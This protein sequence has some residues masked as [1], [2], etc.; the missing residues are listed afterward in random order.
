[1][2][3]KLKKEFK[4]IDNVVLFGLSAG[5]NLVLG[6][7]YWAILNNLPLPKGVVV[8][9]PA[10]NCDNTKFTRSNIWSFNCE[11]LPHAYLRMFSK[12]YL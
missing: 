7:C 5:G 6:V 12:A 10:L 2:T 3:N 1:M 4:K 9:F 11:F 8:A